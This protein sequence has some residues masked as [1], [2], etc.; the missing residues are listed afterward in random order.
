MSVA[1]VSMREQFGW[2]AAVEGLVLGSFFY[3]CE[4][5]PLAPKL[6]RSSTHESR[7]A[8]IR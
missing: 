8:Q 2:D 1:I 7:H 5:C 4:L 6:H 3:G